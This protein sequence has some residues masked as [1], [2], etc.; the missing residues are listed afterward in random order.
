MAGLD[1]IWCPTFTFARFQSLVSQ[2]TRVNLS[3]VIQVIALL[4]RSKSLSPYDDAWEQTRPSSHP[5]HLRPHP[6]TL[7]TALTSFQLSGL[8]AVPPASGPLCLL[9]PLSGILFQLILAK[10]VPSPASSSY[11]NATFSPTRWPIPFQ[12]FILLHSTYRHLAYYIFSI[13]IMS[14]ACLHNTSSMEARMFVFC[15]PLYPL[16]LEHVWALS[17]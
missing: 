7:P 3:N 15:S 5:L 11:P 13:C 4:K 1:W 6:I 14:V 10:P 8:P 9:F 12:G 2:A 16:C 17:R